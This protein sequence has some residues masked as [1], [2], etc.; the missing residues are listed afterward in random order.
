MTVF[1]QI[2]FLPIAYLIVLMWVVSAN[3]LGKML[4]WRLV[5]ATSGS[6]HELLAR[7]INISVTGDQISI[8]LF[9]KRV[10]RNLKIQLVFTI[11]PDFLNQLEGLVLA[12]SSL[13]A[14]NYHKKMYPEKYWSGCPP[15]G[16]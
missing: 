9:E 16:I 5:Q 7:Q 3:V 1:H 12:I 2:E 8:H 15:N 14:L 10:M 11:L 13:E 4:G 6:L